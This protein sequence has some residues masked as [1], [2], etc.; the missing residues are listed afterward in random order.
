[1]LIY[2]V[3]SSDLYSYTLFDHFF[4]GLILEEECAE[5]HVV[6]MFKPAEMD[7]FRHPDL[8][9]MPRNEQA[10]IRGAWFIFVYK[11]LPQ[12]NEEWGR[13]LK[14]NHVKDKPNI[15]DY[16]SLSDEVLARWVINCKYDKLMEEKNQG[17]PQKDP[18]KKGK[19]EGPHESRVLLNLYC[20]EY[21][22]TR[23]SFMVQN[24]AE[25]KKIQETWNDIF[26]KACELYIPD[27][28]KLQETKKKSYKVDS[29]VLPGMDDDW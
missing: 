16:T 20:D 14:D 10:N 8:D 19:K 1:M 15:Y 27:K 12:V 24:S 3:G 21:K 4:S 22:K 13:V 25:C 7:G 18:D 29:A 9:S 6:W 28:F 17:W 2:F 26:W 11:I 23:E 5:G